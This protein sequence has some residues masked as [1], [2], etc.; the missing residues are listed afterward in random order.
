ECFHRADTGQ[1]LA[2]VGH[3]GMRTQTWLGAQLH[4][5]GSECQLQQQQPDS[6]QHKAQYRGVQQ[7][8]RQ[9]QVQAK[10]L[11]AQE[12]HGGDGYQPVQDS[13]NYL[14]HKP[15][16]H[17]PPTSSPYVPGDVPKLG[18]H[19]QELAQSPDKPEPES[20]KGGSQ[21]TSNGQAM[22]WNQEK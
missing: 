7:R 16:Q 13:A 5:A 1:S 9:N 15:E 2:A 3:E 21:Q 4:L 6:A 20:N 22:V 10:Y 8:R 18:I 12:R 11:D 14:Q 19:G 17:Q